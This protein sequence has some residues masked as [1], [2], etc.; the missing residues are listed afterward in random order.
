M[1][2]ESVSCVL[3][4]EIQS[5]WLSL[6]FWNMPSM[7]PFVKPYYFLALYLLFYFLIS[8]CKLLFL[9]HQGSTQMPSPQRKKPF[10]GHSNVD[11]FVILNHHILY[12]IHCNYFNFYLILSFPRLGLRNWYPQ[13]WCFDRCFDMENWRSLKFSLTSSQPPSLPGHSTKL[14]SDIPLSSWTH[15]RR[16]QLALV[17]SLS[18]HCLNSY[19]RKTD[20]SPSVHLDR[21]CH[22]PLSVLQTH[23]FC[24]KPLYVLQAHW[25]FWKIIYCPHPPK[26]STSP[27][28]PFP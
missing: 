9:K 25:T 3:L 15:Q 1:S 4:L 16:K 18:F 8:L 27:H 21:L 26:S 23:R 24:A 5:Q 6:N 12:V 13:I 10:F 7:F 22:R 11:T 19:C 2:V 20:R 14:F 17:P 28:L